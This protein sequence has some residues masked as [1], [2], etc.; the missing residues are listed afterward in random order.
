MSTDN[1]D[2]QTSGDGLLD[3]RNTIP[4]NPNKAA[5]DALFNF[6][7]KTPPEAVDS[8]EEVKE[9]DP[10]VSEETS[11]VEE[12]DT[13]ETGAEDDTPV[14]DETSAEAE[15]EPSNEDLI[16]VDYDEAKKFTYPIKIKGEVK[17]MSFHEIQNQLAQVESAGKASREAKE[18]LKEVEAKQTELDSREESLKALDITNAK[19]QEMVVLDWRY[20]V[21]AQ[22]MQAAKGDQFKNLYDVQ[23]QIV[24]EF[25]TLK[26]EVDEAKAS[27]PKAELPDTLAKVIPSN[28][29]KEAEKVIKE[30]HEKAKLWDNYKSKAAKPKIQ[31]KKTMVKGSG[32]TPKSAKTKAEQEANRRL[33]R[34]VGTPEDTNAALKA[35]MQGLK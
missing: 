2:I 34:G 14:E 27:M 25:N 6:L 9:E 28:I 7:N 18:Q 20:K 19:E 3:A 30:L 16:E 1:P 21:I 32:V 24:Q 23:Q 12:T 15:E 11:E 33:K 17:N 22:Q 31:G 13:E 10:V 4:D 35:V 8:V 29:S 5:D 26:G